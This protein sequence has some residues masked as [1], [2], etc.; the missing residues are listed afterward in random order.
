MQ[1]QVKTCFL[2]KVLL[3][4]LERNTC[5]E[6]ENVWLENHYFKYYVHGKYLYFFISTRKSKLFL[7]VITEMVSCLV[8]LEDYSP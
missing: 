6:V 7:R 2:A 5:K 1:L 4:N 3:L 8:L